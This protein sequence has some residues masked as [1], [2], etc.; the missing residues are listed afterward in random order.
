MQGVFPI[1]LVSLVTICTFVLQNICYDYFPVSQMLYRLFPYEING[2]IFK[3]IPV[4]KW[5]GVKWVR[6]RTQ[7]GVVASVHLRRMGE[8]L[9]FLCVRTFIG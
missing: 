2:C 9:P 3:M 7:W 6:V 1:L 8:F 4:R 5:E